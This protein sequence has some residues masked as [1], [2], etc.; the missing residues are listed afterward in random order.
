[1]IM[2]GR[3]WGRREN[4]KARRMMGFLLFAV[5]LLIIFA[6]FTRQV[7]PLLKRLAESK[8]ESITLKIINDRVGQLVEEEAV[9]YESLVHIGYNTNGQIAYVGTDMVKLNS[10][11]SHISSKIQECFDTYDFGTID[12][13]MGTVVG[14]DYFVG[15]GPVIPF[16]V[17]MSCLVECSFS[18]VF[19]DAGINQTRHQIMLQVTGTTFAVASWCRTTSTVTTNFMIAETVIVGDVPEYYTNVDSGKDALQN[20][21]DYGYDIN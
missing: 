3:T 6:L 10:F 12:I 13:P 17:E 16:K 19:D 2:H 18:N 4:K 7:Q 9:T 11:K 1:M 5:G 21:N 8:A 20:I 14:G 15:R